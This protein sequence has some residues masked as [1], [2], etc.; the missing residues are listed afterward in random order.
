M[1]VESLPCRSSAL[2]SPG[3]R[4]TCRQ[5]TREPLLLWGDA[6]PHNI[7]VEDGQVSALL[8]WEL[9]HTGHPMEDLGAAVWACLGRYPQDEVIAGYEEVSGRAVDRDLV[10]YFA[11]LGCVSRTIMQLA[12]IDSF[13]R[14]ETNALNLAGLGLTLPTANLRRAADYARLARGRG[15]DSSPIDSGPDELRLRPD[16]TETLEGIARFITDDVLPATESAHLQRGLKTAV[17][18]LRATA[19]RG[20]EEPDRRALL[21]ERLDALFDRLEAAGVVAPESPR[22]ADDLEAAAVRVESDP[23]FADHRADVRHTLLADLLLRA[24]SLEAVTR[25]YGRDVQ[26]GP[27]FTR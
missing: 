8:D 24:A 4:R 14:A 6:G 13:V 17:G 12:G 18:L 20:R 15:R 1:I 11:V 9:S 27:G 10:A 21:Q 23:A 16:P 3:S 7:L 26:A 19:Q 2:C 25:L 22:G 5:P